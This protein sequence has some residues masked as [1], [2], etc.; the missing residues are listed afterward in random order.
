MGGG[1]RAGGQVAFVVLS[2]IESF[3]FPNIKS[4]HEERAEEPAS[5]PNP[6]QVL[7]RELGKRKAC[8][9]GGL[10]KAPWLTLAQGSGARAAPPLRLAEGRS[11]CAAPLG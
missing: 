9:L 5:P 4:R 1:S 11:P 2:S 10:Q 6:E 3:V 8:S 7:G